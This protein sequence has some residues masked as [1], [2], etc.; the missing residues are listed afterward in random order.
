MKLIIKNLSKSFSNKVVLDNINFEFK[1]SK[2][3]AL[4]GKNGSGKTTL[5]NCFDDTYK[6]DGEVLID[7]TIKLNAD[8]LGF[9]P[10]NPVIPEFLSGEQFIKYFIELHKLENIDID[11]YL[12]LLD[13]DK[14][15]FKRLI[16][17]YSLG[18]KQ[19]IQILTYLILKP[20]ILLLDEPLTNLDIITAKEIKDILK[21]IKKDRIIIIST[22]ILELAKS[23]CDEIVILNNGKLTLAQNL[24]DSS[25]EAKVME[26]LQDEKNDK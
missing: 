2:I 7:N 24:D 15:D 11:E 16:K 21:K 5:F 23:M 10:A 14:K 12:K 3:Y 13:F 25:F 8:N 17:E 18:M 26:M 19:K 1:D 6:Y 22:H 20:K 4:L 9:L